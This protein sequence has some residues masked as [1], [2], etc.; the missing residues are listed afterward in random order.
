MSKVKQSENKRLKNKQLEIKAIKI[1]GFKSIRD[2]DLPLNSLNVLIGA[3]GSGKSNFISLFN[4]L[5]RI[6]EERLQV[7]VAQAGGPDSLLHY[8][9]KTT[10]K[11]EVKI[12]FPPNS[13]EFSLIPTQDN[14]LIFDE[15]TCYFHDPKYEIPCKVDLGGGQ[16]ETALN[17][18]DVEWGQGVIEH[19]LNSIESW[20]IYHFHDTSPSSLMKQKGNLDDNLMF[21]AD[22]A[23]LAAYLFLLREKHRQHYDNIVATV[24]LAAPFFDDFILR[25]DPLN[26]RMIQL[27]WREKASDTYFNAHALSDGTLRFICLAVLLLQPHPPSLILLDE[28][29]LGLHPYAI[30]LLADLLKSAATHTQVI[31][32]TQSVTLVNQF[33]YPDIIVVER[34]DRQS[35]FRQLKGEDM[36]HWLDEYGLGDLWEKNVIGG[37]PAHE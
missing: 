30:N 24:Q 31:V 23:N 26:P 27:E 9:R 12:D 22:A 1:R 33:D 7:F 29:E 36:E 14:S 15:E 10:D 16:K 18:N 17:S 21:R 3:N 5:N 32:A 28:P 2:L 25:P 8:G 34:E 11:L 6:I 35:V 4:L 19:V 37:R 13:Y 20:I